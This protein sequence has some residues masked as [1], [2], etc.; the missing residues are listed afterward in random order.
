VN[1]SFFDASIINLP[2][3]SV[4]ADSFVTSTVIFTSGTFY[5]SPKLSILLTGTSRALAKSLINNM[6]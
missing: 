5:P 2:S 1:A 4:V 3:K 6:L